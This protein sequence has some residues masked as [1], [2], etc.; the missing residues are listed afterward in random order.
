MRVV[1]LS[2]GK[3]GRRVDS[4]GIH[5]QMV[6]QEALLRYD[7]YHTNDRDMRCYPILW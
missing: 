1:C 4:Y 7:D 5:T 2:V 3:D 6:D